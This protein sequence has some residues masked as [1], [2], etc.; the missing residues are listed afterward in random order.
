MT[1]DN[2]KI[3]KYNRNIVQRIFKNKVSFH[4][5]QACLPIEEKIRILV[6]LQEIVL[7]TRPVIDPMD[8]RRVWDLRRYKPHQ[9]GL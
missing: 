6:E 1:R 5:E 2:D 8:N 3:I 7:K 4:R 9:S